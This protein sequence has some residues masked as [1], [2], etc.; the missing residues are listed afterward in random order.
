MQNRLSMR[1]WL[2]RLGQEVTDTATS[3]EVET[4]RRR[5]MLALVLWQLPPW[6]VACY[7]IYEW[8]FANA[9]FAPLR[10]GLFAAGYGCGWRWA[11]SDVAR[12]LIEGAAVRIPRGQAKQVGKLLQLVADEVGGEV[13]EPFWNSS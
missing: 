13:A 6:M 5:D 12:R 2:L 8:Q 9:D 10:L 11:S 3:F 7:F 1:R 4:T